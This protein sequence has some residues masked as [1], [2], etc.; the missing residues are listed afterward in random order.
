MKPY[1]S[2]TNSFLTQKSTL[3]FLRFLFKFIN[4]KKHKENQHQ[5][6]E[7]NRGNVNRDYLLRMFETGSKNTAK[8]STLISQIRSGKNT[9][10]F[11]IASTH[12]E[13]AILLCRT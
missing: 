3:Y 6:R 10:R 12:K 11:S 5:Q 13:M 8:K 2:D 9:R 4:E 7:H 1:Y